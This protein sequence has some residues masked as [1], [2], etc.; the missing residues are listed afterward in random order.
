MNVHY[1]WSCRWTAQN[2]SGIWHER[3]VQTGIANCPIVKLLT[4]KNLI[5][6]LNLQISDDEDFCPSDMSESTDDDKF[7]AKTTYDR[8]GNVYIFCSL[9]FQMIFVQVT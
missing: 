2:V 1:H 3:S 8:K 4:Y 7:V 5:Y 9:L 6:L